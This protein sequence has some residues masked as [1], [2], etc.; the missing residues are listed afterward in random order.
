M[1]LGSF[2]VV[3]TN[4]AI[5]L[6]NVNQTR[7]REEGHILKLAIWIKIKIIYYNPL[8]YTLRQGGRQADRQTGRQ[9]G[10]Q[11]GR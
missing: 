11:V 1:L 3:G 7:S 9:A 4:F 8:S 2:N 10:K 6:Q 5:V